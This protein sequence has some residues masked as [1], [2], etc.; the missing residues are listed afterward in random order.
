MQ[1]RSRSK[2]SFYTFH[3]SV[4]SQ[5]EI[6]LRVMICIL[7][8]RKLFIESVSVF[9]DVS[10][11]RVSG[12]RCCIGL[13]DNLCLVPTWSMS[14][15]VPSMQRVVFNELF[16]WEQNSP[17][18]YCWRNTR[19]K[20]GGYTEYKAVDNMFKRVFTNEIDHNNYNPQNS[21]YVSVHMHELRRIEYW[22]HI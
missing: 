3:T 16:H 17:F 11:K 6:K 19:A 1:R 12:S 5:K 20:S 4:Q 7:L 22:I 15:I 10:M 2:N 9:S 14:L 13:Q 21:L 8:T 18:K